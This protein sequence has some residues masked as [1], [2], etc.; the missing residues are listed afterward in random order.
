MNSRSYCLRDAL[1]AALEVDSRIKAV[2]RT[3]KTEL[4]YAF[5]GRLAI[6]IQPQALLDLPNVPRARLSAAKRLLD[7]VVSRNSQT[8]D[9]IVEEG[10]WTAQVEEK[11]L[12]P[13][14]DGNDFK[15]HAVFAVPFGT[16]SQD[17]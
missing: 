15:L 6:L 10:P 3:Q 8:F 9:I 11:V 14:I 7:H 4:R 16:N 12:G 5:D 2:A 17:L 1:G 13:P